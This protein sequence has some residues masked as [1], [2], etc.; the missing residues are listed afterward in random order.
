MLTYDQ[1][2][3]MKSQLEQNLNVNQLIIIHS[4]QFSSTFFCLTCRISH[5]LFDLS[6]QPKCSL[7]SEVEDFKNQPSG[8][9]YH[10][11]VAGRSNI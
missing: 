10:K 11:Y 3:I 8:I 1:N 6:L 7:L 9:S 2:N 5:L 4:T